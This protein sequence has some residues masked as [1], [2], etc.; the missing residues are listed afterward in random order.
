LITAV[1]NAIWA[2]DKDQPICQINLV[3]DRL[4]GALAEPR[5]YLFL[6]GC[7]AGLTLLLVSMGIYS[8]MAYSVAQRTNEIGIRMAL[9]AQTRDV[10][11]LIVK[12]GMRLA[13]FGVALGLLAAFLLTRPIENLLFGA[14]AT[15]PLTFAATT[16][17][18][19]GIALLA[20]WIPARRAT[21]VD[22]LVA[23]RCE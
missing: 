15:D 7:F 1:K 2:L 16:L 19:L 14:S 9:G 8:V 18:L 10:L 3:E 4:S 21:K 6:F 13:L 5:F 20:C 11:R 23:L 22:P 12:Q 17:L